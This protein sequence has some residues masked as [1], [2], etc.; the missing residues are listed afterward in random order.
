M[1]FHKS[2]EF[3]FDNNETIM[4]AF[5]LDSQFSKVTSSV[6]ASCRILDLTKLSN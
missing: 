1:H 6:L 4:L 2:V 3:K 5:E